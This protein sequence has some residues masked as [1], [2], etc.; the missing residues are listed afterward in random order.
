MMV[1]LASALTV[2]AMVLTGLALFRRLA[3]VLL[4]GRHNELSETDL[5][6]LGILPGL[7]LVGTLA[8]YLAVL[9]LLRVGVVL[10]LAA[11][12]FY[13]CRREVGGMLVHLGRE[14]RGWFVRAARGNLFPVIAAGVFLTA[15][16]LALLACVVPSENMDVWAFHIPL[17]QSFVAHHGLVLQ[18]VSSVLYSTQPNFQEMLFAVAMMAVPSFIAAGVVNVAV[19]F[20]FIVILPSF[21][22]RMRS[23]HFLAAL[24][25]FFWWQNFALGAAEPMADLPRSCFSVAAF[26]FAYR[27]AQSFRLFDLAVCAL[28]AG[29]AAASK[30][31]EL[32]TAAVIVATLT[33]LMVR[34]EGAWRHLTIAAAIYL[35]T[36]GV[37]YVK[38][39]IE[40][41]NPVFPFLF[42]HPGLSD[43]Y[44]VDYM[45]DLTRPFNPADRIYST[46][47]LTV[48]GWQDFAT[49]LQR[50]F[51]DLEY[52]AILVGFGLLLPQRRRWMLPLWSVV[53]FLVWYARMFN[54]LRWAIPAML[55][56]L[57]AAFVTWTWLADRLA[58]AW[59]PQWPT[60][61]LEALTRK[62]RGFSDPW[63]VIAGF[64]V[65]LFFVTGAPP[66][67]LRYGH[68]ILP[69][70]MTHDFFMALIIP[71]R[72]DRYMA[73]TRH[74]YVLYRY[75]GQH[76]LKMVIQPFDLGGDY[77]V[78]MYNGGHKNDWIMHP[79]ALPAEP[80]GTDA[81]VA[82]NNIHY[83]IDCDPI[84][85]IDADRMGTAH[86]ALAKAVVA[87][88]KPHARLILRDNNMYLYEI[89][90]AQGRPAP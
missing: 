33:P 57:S 28:L 77:Y 60:M 23:L 41:G 22:V 32:M 2:L 42:A 46:D 64:A 71:G 40:F 29:A 35:V 36:A 67:P 72:M 45:K 12:V 15:L 20:G 85:P 19:F 34:R 54:A 86:I 3:P 11:V 13:V 62:L 89:L 25:A 70:W 38:N 5:M 82:R 68:P 80:A 75:I 73:E 78:S 47:L 6:L 81:F 39:A 74:S 83:F 84:D 58:E 44:M 63:V 9:H 69:Q 30:Y 76:D 52:A 14:M 17:A 21:G 59:D 56:L 50:Y 51:G 37:W 87:R 48:K 24:L 27:Y 10:F 18:Q 55:M 61:A 90:P 1:V 26:L 4:G 16:A 49:V 8:T 88:L 53:L 66:L 7:A 31:T 79:L 65:A 43:Q